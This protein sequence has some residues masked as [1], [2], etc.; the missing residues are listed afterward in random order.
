MIQAP[1][2]Q[3][4]MIIVTAKM[5]AIKSVNEIKHEIRRPWCSFVFTSHQFPSPVVKTM[6]YNTGK[7]QRNVI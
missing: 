5:L 6:L 4:T 1:L 2:V 7:I 3:F